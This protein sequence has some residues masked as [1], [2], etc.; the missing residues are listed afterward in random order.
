MNR[1]T[2][3]FLKWSILCI[4]FTVNTYQMLHMAK[5]TVVHFNHAIMFWVRVRATSFRNI[6]SEVGGAVCWCWLTR[7][8]WRGSV[9]L[10]WYNEGIRRLCFHNKGVFII[11]QRVWS[12]AHRILTAHT[13]S[14]N[15]SLTREPSCETNTSVTLYFFFWANSHKIWCISLRTKNK[16]DF[17]TVH[18]KYCQFQ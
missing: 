14:Y 1:K 15:S 7:Q 11:S 9:S 8:Y 18:Y 3:T 13:W 10:H 2:I 4:Y 12:K 6:K 5:Y 17:R 16:R